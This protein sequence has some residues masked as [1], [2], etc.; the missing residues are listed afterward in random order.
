MDQATI[1][2]TTEKNRENR[3]DQPERDW[4]RGRLGDMSIQL[5]S[6]SFER[7]YQRVRQAESRNGFLND[8]QLQSIVEEAAAGSEALE[9]VAESFR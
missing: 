8:Q 1:F 4:L 7:V 9:G 2:A 5:N 3:D 6:A